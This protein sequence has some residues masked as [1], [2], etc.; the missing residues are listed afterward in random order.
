MQYVKQLRLHM[1]RTLPT[2]E[3]GTSQEA[4]KRAG[5]SSPTQFSREYRRMFGMSPASER[6]T[7]AV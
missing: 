3:G 2:L 6:R 5:Y 7:R 4:A 1:A